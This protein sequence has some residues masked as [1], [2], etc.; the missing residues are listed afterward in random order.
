MMPENSVYGVWPRSGEIDIME[1]RGNTVEY[2]SGGRDVYTSTLHWGMYFHSTQRCCFSKISHIVG[3]TAAKDSFWRTT[4]GHAL[5][6]TDYTSDFHTY[7]IEWSKDYIFSYLDNR[8]VQVLFVGFQGKEGLWDLGK[9]STMEENS[10][11]LENPWAK[12][13]KQNAPFDEEF[14]LILNVAVGAKN[15]WFP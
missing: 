13:S 1:S 5:R 9:F 14:Y 11:I 12:G 15:G 2:P 10:T 3:P 6:R 7:G 8:L 4:K